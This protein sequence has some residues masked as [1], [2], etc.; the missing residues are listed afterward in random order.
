MALLLKTLSHLGCVP[1]PRPQIPE[2]VRL[3]VTGQLGLLW[4]PL[5][6]LFLARQHT[7]LSP[8]ANS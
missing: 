6:R 7:R 1:D 3:F 5:R 4:D 8:G 2:E